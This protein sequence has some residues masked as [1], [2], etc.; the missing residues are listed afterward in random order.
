[1]R[2]DPA[3]RERAV[4]QD[5]QVPLP[6]GVEARLDQASAEAVAAE[7]VVGFGMRERDLVAAQV[8]QDEPGELAIRADLEPR[9]IRI[10]GYLQVHDTSHDPGYPVTEAG[11]S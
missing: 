3:Q 7:T 11:R 1:M 5:R 4:R 6:G 10:V 9:L 2:G 8:I